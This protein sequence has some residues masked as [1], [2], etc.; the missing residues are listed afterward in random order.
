M[1]HKPLHCILSYCNIQLGTIYWSFFISSNLLSIYEILLCIV[2]LCNIQW[3]RKILSSRGYPSLLVSIYPIICQFFYSYS[4]PRIV[5]VQDI[6][7]KHFPSSGLTHSH[8][9]S[10]RSHI[11]RLKILGNSLGWHWVTQTHSQ[12]SHK[13]LPLTQMHLNLIIRSSSILPWS[14]RKISWQKDDR[15]RQIFLTCQRSGGYRSTLPT[16]VNPEFGIWESRK[17]F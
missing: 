10:W 11:F 7:K 1:Y 17:N 13:H 9:S 5:G 15:I 4:F 2:I 8:H 6:Q 3:R 14:S 16:A 12:S